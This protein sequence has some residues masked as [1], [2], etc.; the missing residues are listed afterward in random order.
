MT[1]CYQWDEYL[2]H[3]ASWQ[4]GFDEDRSKRLDEG[5]TRFDA[6]PQFAVDVFARMLEEDPQPEECVDEDRKFYRHLHRELGELR[7]FK[8]LRE[9]TVGDEDA[10]GLAADCLL[11]DL[12][13]SQALDDIGGYPSTEEEAAAIRMLHDMVVK[14]N[15]TDEERQDIERSTEDLWDSAS[16]KLGMQKRSM[17]RFD[18]TDVRDAL[19]AACEKA[20]EA[21]RERDEMADAFAFG[22]PGS[23]IPASRAERNGV[24]RAL[25]PHLAKQPNLKRLIEQAGRLRRLMR[26]AQLTKPD[27]EATEVAGVVLG[28]ELDLVMPDEF[29]FAARSELR[30]IFLR[31]FAERGLQQVELKELPKTEQGPIIFCV[32]CSGSMYG[33]PAAWAG[34]VALAFF[35]AAMH[36]K[37][38]FAIIQFHSEVGHVEVFAPKKIADINAV[39][40]SV[41]LLQASGGT[42]FDPPLQK[43]LELLDQGPDL[44]KADIVF[45]TDGLARVS[46]TIQQ[47]VNTEKAERALR[48]YAIYIGGSRESS[49]DAI[50]TNSFAIS[51]L[52]NDQASL[53]DLFSEI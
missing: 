3:Q 26:S 7:E 36:Q 32:D 52:A 50:A 24:A 4:L 2:A 23:G 5:E 14:G 18:D 9:R 41:L 21:I 42:R 38:T 1:W 22:E 48:L 34:G 51:N 37:R 43:A 29:A 31:K 35:E 30:P 8:T 49:L 28:R 15:L 53:S 39:M 33:E 13:E 16:V 47:R 10:A 44:N 19:R 11:S 17:E 27:H 46:S 12:L 20:A 40:Q 25:A 6:W 45:C